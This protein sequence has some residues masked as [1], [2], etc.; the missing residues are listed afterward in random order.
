MTNHKVKDAVW[1]K[2]L[3][4]DL[5]KIIRIDL[6]NY[7]L[8]FSKGKFHIFECFLTFLYSY[9]FDNGVFCCWGFF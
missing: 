3:P 5:P 6:L 1:S 9:T 2:N 7:K 4:L 8:L